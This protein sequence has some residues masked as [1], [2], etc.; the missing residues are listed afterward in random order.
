MV[1]LKILNGLPIP[2]TLKSDL[3]TPVSKKPLLLLFVILSLTLG[4]LKAVN[5][6]EQVLVQ[7]EQTTLFPMWVESRE[8]SSLPL[9]TTIDEPKAP[10]IFWLEQDYDDTWQSLRTF[11]LLQHQSQTLNIYVETQNPRYK[12]VFHQYIEESISQ[13]S[14]ALEGRLHHRFVDDPAQAHVVFTWVEGFPTPHRA[15]ETEIEIGRSLIKIKT[16]DMPDNI[17]RT[18]ILHELGHA[19]GL[20]GHSP[21][22]ED[23]MSSGKTWDTEEAYLSYHAT[24]SQRDIRAIRHLYTTGWCPGEDVYKRV[25]S[26]E[27]RT[28]CLSAINQ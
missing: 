28:A 15:G 10:E 1:R 20:A 18:N 23:I 3:E 9:V 26:S 6:E 19:L 17:T 21:Y 24:L 22:P 25:A 13:W 14:Q 8:L 27:N 7:F 5:A 4:S 11:N 12:P 2:S 16:V